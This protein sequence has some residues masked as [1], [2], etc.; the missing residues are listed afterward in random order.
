MDIAKGDRELIR[1]TMLR[2]GG[3]DWEHGIARIHKSVDTGIN[4]P[5]GNS[6]VDDLA[7]E[8]N[9]LNITTREIPVRYDLA[10]DKKRV[11]FS[12]D[13]T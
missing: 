10:A 4:Y 1:I 9:A 13:Q 7:H 2:R 3:G 12:F 11:R 8:K 6:R 5:F